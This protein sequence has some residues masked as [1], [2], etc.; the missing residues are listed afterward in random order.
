[1][2]ALNREAQQSGFVSLELGGDLTPRELQE[3]YDAL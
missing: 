1:L 2:R 3:L